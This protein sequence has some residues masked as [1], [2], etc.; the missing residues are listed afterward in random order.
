[1]YKPVDTHG[2]RFASDSKLLLLSAVAH[3]AEQESAQ[4]P[5]NAYP[6]PKLWPIAQKQ[7]ISR[8]HR[9]AVN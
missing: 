1:V 7:M 4:Y 9:W 3:R 2:I 8:D 5:P 6:D